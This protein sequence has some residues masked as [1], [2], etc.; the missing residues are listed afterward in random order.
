MTKGCS[1]KFIRY[2]MPWQERNSHT[3]LFVSKGSINET[4]SGFSLFWLVSEISVSKLCEKCCIN[5]CHGKKKYFKYQ[6]FRTWKSWKSTYPINPIEQS[7]I[8][9]QFIVPWLFV[10]EKAAKIIFLLNTSFSYLLISYYMYFWKL[11]CVCPKDSREGW[12]YP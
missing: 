12:E 11:L 7:S 1:I 3:V 6:N 8:V 10:K 4:V 2:L 5:G 9:W